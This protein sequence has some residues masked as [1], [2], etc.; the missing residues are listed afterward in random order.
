M[1]NDFTD[2][3]HWQELAAKLTDYTLP[4]YGLPCTLEKM[5]LWL[6]RTEISPRQYLTASGLKNLNEYVEL[7]PTF[8]LRAF[9]GELLEMKAEMT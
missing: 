2:D 5:L 6:E 7:N 3:V 9:V 8:P 4:K 1:Q